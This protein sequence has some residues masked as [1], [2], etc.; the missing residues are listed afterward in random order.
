M[1][2]VLRLPS[3]RW[4]YKTTW[5]WAKPPSNHSFTRPGLPQKL[6]TWTPHEL[7]RRTRRRPEGKLHR[8]WSPR[9]LL[10]LLIWHYPAWLLV[11]MRIIIAPKNPDS[12]PPPPAFQSFS[13]LIWEPMDSAKAG[14]MYH[15]SPSK[16]DSMLNHR[17]PPLD[18][19]PQNLKNVLTN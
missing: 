10:L 1:L 9:S 4:A 7:G 15:S 8:S 13:L 12:P 17:R 3:F 5:V 16:T 19:T 2:L 11:C 14:A 6:S 18:S